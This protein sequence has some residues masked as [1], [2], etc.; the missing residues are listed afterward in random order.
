MKTWLKNKVLEIEERKD[1][2]RK[3]RS[4]IIPGPFKPDLPATPPAEYSDDE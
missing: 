4:F 2:E 3:T 1:D